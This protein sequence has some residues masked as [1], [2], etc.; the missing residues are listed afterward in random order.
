M[1]PPLYRIAVPSTACS[2][3][4]DSSRMV[5]DLRKKVVTKDNYGEQNRAATDEELFAAGEWSRTVE[6]EIADR[7]AR[8]HLTPAPPPPADLVA[9][10][11]EIAGHH[12]LLSDASAMLDR[13]IEHGTS[14]DL[15]S[16]ARLLAH[17]LRRARF[18]MRDV[19]DKHLGTQLDSDIPF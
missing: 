15:K 3:V 13:A 10:I 9:A 1:T 17:H 16:A 4:Q 7:E 2:H 6:A 11:A 8:K 12:G 14:D 18:D 5:V 19:A